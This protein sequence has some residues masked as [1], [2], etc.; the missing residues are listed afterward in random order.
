MWRSPENC[1]SSSAACHPHVSSP[2]QLSCCELEVLSYRSLLNP[3]T[4]VTWIPM[5]LRCL[6]QGASNKHTNIRSLN[7]DE[8]FPASTS[9]ENEGKTANGRHRKPFRKL[10]YSTDA[11]NNHCRKPSW[12]LVGRS[13][14][15]TR[16][17][18][19]TENTAC[20]YKSRYSWTNRLQHRLHL[21][22]C[23]QRGEWLNLRGITTRSCLEKQVTNHKLQRNHAK[24]VWGN[25][26]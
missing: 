15:I 24:L 2:N 12:V 23:S 13:H 25:W 21:L 20:P 8:P 26:Y 7:A 22:N 16:W 19:I 9:W 4:R 5:P 14:S 6:C 1:C 17:R 11:R 3:S 10:F 18:K